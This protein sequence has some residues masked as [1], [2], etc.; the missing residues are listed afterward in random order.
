MS[1]IKRIQIPINLS[2]ETPEQW[3]ILRI[4]TED[5][6]D[7]PYYKVFAGWRGGYHDGDRWRL[8]SGITRVEEDDDY[9]Y[10]YG[11]SGSCYKCLKNAYGLKGSYTQ[12][13]LGDLID[14]A[15]LS[16]I[17]IEVMPESTNWDELTK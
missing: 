1:K 15:N 4:P 14:K 7:V 5:N 2:I 3:V 13:I 11:Y 16:N 12:G 17:N 8:N 6:I 9:Y 10:F